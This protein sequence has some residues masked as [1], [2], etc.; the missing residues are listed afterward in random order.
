MIIELQRQWVPPEEEPT[1]EI[2]GVCGL[3]LQEISVLAMVRTDDGADAGQ[4]CMT[5]VAY[6]GRRNP[7]RFPTEAEY[8]ALLKRY[9]EPMYPNMED[10][11]R[12]GEEAGYLEP[13]G[14][15]ARDATVWSLFKLD[16]SFPP[17]YS[18]EDEE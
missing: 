18:K 1:G 11:E 3:A 12:A 17:I 4:A 13:S 16:C 8:R 15:A 9:P 14:L 10:L 6:L 5:C 2:C 7:E